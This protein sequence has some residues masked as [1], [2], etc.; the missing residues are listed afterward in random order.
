LNDLPIE[1]TNHYFGVPVIRAT[2][3]AEYQTALQKAFT[4]DGPTVIEAV[5]NEND[6]DDLV[7]KS[8]K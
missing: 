8:N 5:V 4:S 1:P 7:L 6:Y 2:N 3:L